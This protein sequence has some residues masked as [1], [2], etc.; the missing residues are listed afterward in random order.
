MASFHT[1]R[2]G[3]VVSESVDLPVIRWT[4]R[5]A[6][7]KVDVT[8][9]LSNGFAEFIAGV[10]EGSVTF[11][12]LWDAD[13]LPNVAPGLVEGDQVACVLHC[14]DTGKTFSGNLFLESV[15]YNSQARNQPITVRCDGSF[16]GSYTRPS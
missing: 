11:V 12:L 5:F 7:E 8:S 16:S 6:A 4:G 2:R 13:Q 3:K 9:A 15:E 10:L 14:D 1:G